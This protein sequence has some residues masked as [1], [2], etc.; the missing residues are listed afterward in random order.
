MSGRH[1]WG[2][3]GTLGVGSGK[4]IKAQSEPL[5]YPSQVTV[6][7]DLDLSQVGILTVVKARLL[8]DFT[9]GVG[10]IQRVCDIAA[11]VS[12]SGVASSVFAQI[13]DESPAATSESYTVTLTMSRY[14]RPG[15]VTP[16][17]TG[18]N[19]AVGATS[20]VV[21]DVPP[22]ATGVYV[23]GNAFAG[24]HVKQL[25]KHDGSVVVAE[26]DVVIGQVMP[27]SQGARF[28]ELDNASG[29]STNATV[30]FSIDG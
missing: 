29:S 2:F 26:S 17:R 15:G 21:I 11:G 24:L 12:I 14:P 10:R 30:Q 27:L 23:F 9:V 5:D 22:G 20:F 4:D 13:I 1:G 16:V 28:I 3:P 7:G 18:F 19:G 25:G 6:Q 8:V